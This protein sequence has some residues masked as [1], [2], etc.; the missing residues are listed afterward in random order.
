[1]KCAMSNLAFYGAGEI[2][3]VAWM[4]DHAVAERNALA[5]VFPQA[6]RLLC[7]FHTLQA[8]WR[9]LWQSSTGCPLKDRKPVMKLFI[10][11]PVPQP[12]LC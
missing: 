4:T 9:F 2:G 6:R 1:M 7:T 12:K 8:L 5:E 11:K 3:P 10:G